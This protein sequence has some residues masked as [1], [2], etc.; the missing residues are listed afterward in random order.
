M[1]VRVKLRIRS[2][3]GGETVETSALVNSGYEADTP[4]LLVPRAL[5]VRLNLWPPP[6]EAELVE[7]GTAGG[8]VR[9]FIVRRAV[10]VWVVTSDR[11]VGPV[12]ADA[13]ISSVEQEVL[14]SDLLGSEL[15]IVILDLRGKWRFRDENTVRL[16]E[17]PQYWY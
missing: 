11:L 2:R 4:Q 8:P 1:A 6:P 17:P 14:I 7:V 13:M 5:A 10:D 9:N 15:G 3:L 12:V 16:S